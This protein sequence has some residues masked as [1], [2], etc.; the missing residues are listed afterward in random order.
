MRA[1]IALSWSV[2]I[3]RKWPFAMEEQSSHG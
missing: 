2:I 1:L 3:F